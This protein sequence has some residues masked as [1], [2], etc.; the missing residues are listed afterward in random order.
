MLTSLV[1]VGH[2][3]YPTNRMGKFQPIPDISVGKW[4]FKSYM[5]PPE[6]LPLSLLPETPWCV[7]YEI[8]PQKLR[9]RVYNPSSPQRGLCGL[10][11]LAIPSCSGKECPSSEP[12]VG[13]QKCFWDRTMKLSMLAASAPGLSWKSM[14]PE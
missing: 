6:P 3:C 9:D 14:S 13:K 4:D 8:S 7:P 11:W 10:A 1:D 5:L 2:H 12:S